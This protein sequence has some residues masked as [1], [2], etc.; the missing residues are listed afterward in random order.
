MFKLFWWFW[1]EHKRDA[2]WFG[3]QTLR[4][5]LAYRRADGMTE[6]GEEELPGNEKNLEPAIA[7]IAEKRDE[8]N[9]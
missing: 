1:T 3:R 7:A 6:T 5:L 8:Y 9:G 2:E 4:Q